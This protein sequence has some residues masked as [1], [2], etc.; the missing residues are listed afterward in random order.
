MRFSRGTSTNEVQPHATVYPS[1]VMDNLS[2][3]YTGNRL[4]K[5]ADAPVAN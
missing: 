2:Y 1:F 5:V 4:M 3:T